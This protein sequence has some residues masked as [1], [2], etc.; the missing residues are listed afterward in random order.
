[1][2]DNFSRMD[3]SDVEEILDQSFMQRNDWTFEENQDDEDWTVVFDE[4]ESRNDTIREWLSN[5]THMQ[6]TAACCIGN[7]YHSIN[8]AFVLARLMENYEGDK[9]KQKFIHLARQIAESSVYGPAEDIIGDFTTFELY[10]G[11]HLNE[12]GIIINEELDDA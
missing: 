7:A 8:I 11:I 5:C 10:Y 1:M 9:L 6:M 3:H 2:I 4:E 12:E